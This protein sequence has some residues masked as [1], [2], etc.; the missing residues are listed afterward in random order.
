[1]GKLAIK[2]RR[3]KSAKADAAEKGRTY[4]I[5]SLNLSDTVHEA[6]NYSIQ[7]EDNA[8]GHDSKWLLAHRRIGQMVNKINKDKL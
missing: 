4:G 8:Y 1:M 5:D 6:D 3:I 2:K 7:W